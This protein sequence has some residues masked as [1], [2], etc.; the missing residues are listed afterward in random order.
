MYIN[1]RTFHHASTDTLAYRDTPETLMPVFGIF[2]QKKIYTSYFANNILET[3]IPMYI[4]LI[5]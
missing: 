4:F 2:P 3:L 1:Q 5:Y